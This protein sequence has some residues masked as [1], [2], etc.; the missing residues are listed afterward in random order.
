MNKNLKATQYSPHNEKNIQLKTVQVFGST[1]QGVDYE[2]GRETTLGY[3]SVP[4]PEEQ[5]PEC[6]RFMMRT[7]K[8][9]D[10]FE[11]TSN[12]GVRLKSELREARESDP[13]E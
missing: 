11:K 1:G 8:A 7:Q 4:Q 6:F 12:R 10:F 2:G 9:A 3:F 5:G 13:S